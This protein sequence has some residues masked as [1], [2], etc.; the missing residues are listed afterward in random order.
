MRRLELGKIALRRVLDQQAIEAAIV[1][2]RIESLTQTSVVTP[3][4][5]EMV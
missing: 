4:N 3:A 5:D 2:S 1:A